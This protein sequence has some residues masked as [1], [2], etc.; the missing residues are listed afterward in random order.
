VTFHDAET[1][2]SIKQWQGELSL[3][4]TDPSTGVEDVGLGGIFTFEQKLCPVDPG[5]C[6]G[7]AIAHVKPS[8]LYFPR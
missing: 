1:N 7:E 4:S 8:K 5:T 2:G 3:L 6:I